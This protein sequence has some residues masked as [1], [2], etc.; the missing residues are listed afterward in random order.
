MFKEMNPEPPQQR[1]EGGEESV[2]EDDPPQRMTLTRRMTWSQKK[3]IQCVKTKP[4][5]WKRARKVVD[6]EI[7]SPENKN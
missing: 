2:T 3:S 1:D 4:K 5:R 6:R 7:T